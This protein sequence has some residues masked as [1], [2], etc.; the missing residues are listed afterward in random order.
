MDDNRQQAALALQPNLVQI[1]LDLAAMRKSLIRIWRLGSLLM[2]ADMA[3]RIDVHDGQDMIALG[4]KLS[5]QRRH[6]AADPAGSTGSALFLQALQRQRELR[7]QAL[8][9]GFILTFRGQLTKRQQIELRGI[10][11]TCI[12]PVFI[13][14]QRAPSLF[15]SKVDVKDIRSKLSGRRQ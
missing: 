13:V 1:V 11:H 10:A 12:L 3:V 2:Q 9:R 14:K 4:D 6:R 7:K 5:R 15:A 8:V